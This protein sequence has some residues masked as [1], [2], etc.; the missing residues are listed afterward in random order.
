METEIDFAGS[1]RCASVLKDCA[2]SCLNEPPFAYSR[3]WSFV[4][5]VSPA[6]R[7]SSFLW[8]LV[9]IVTAPATEPSALMPLL[10]ATTYLPSGEN[11]IVLT[12]DE[13]CPNLRTSRPEPTSQSRRHEPSATGAFGALFA[14]PLNKNLPSGEKASAWTK[15]RSFPNLRHCSPSSDHNRIASSCTHCLPLT[16]PPPPVAMVRPS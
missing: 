5:A 4:M 16:A 11:P 9:L 12:A 1:S 2:T 6:G 13:W 14:L 3:S 7:G 15:K 8:R 10:P